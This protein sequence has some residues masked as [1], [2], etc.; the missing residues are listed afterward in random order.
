[1]QQQ[2]QQPDSAAEARER[3]KMAQPAMLPRR[4]GSTSSSG[5]G[6]E[7]FP[8]GLLVQPTPASPAASSA[9]VSVSSCPPGA[10]PPQS[11]AL[12]SQ[13]GGGGGPAGAQLKKKSGFQITSVTP[14]Q[15]SASLSSNNSI[16]EDTES[17]D[18]LDESH[19]EDFSSSEILD[20]SLSRATDLGE[21]ERSS[22][23]ETLNNFHEADSPGAVSPNQPR[24]AQQPRGLTNGSAHPLHMPHYA[25]GGHP[26]PPSHAGVP[27]PMSAGSPS[28]PSFRRLP[29]AG[30][31]ERPG[32]A[33][34]SSVAA[35]A[36]ATVAHFHAGAIAAGGAVAAA[37]SGR[38]RQVGKTLTNLAAA[39]NGMALPGG[40]HPGNVALSGGIGNGTG[41]PSNTSGSTGHTAA[42]ATATGHLQPAGS[43]SRFRVVKLD[44]SS[45]PFKKGRWTCTE[46]YDKENPGA[47]AESAPVAKTVDALLDVAS[48]RESTSGS[49]VSSTLSHYTESVG[50]GE[51]GAPPGMQPQGFHPQQMEFSTGL[52]SASAPGLPQSMSQSQL[53][54]V[55]LHP[56][57]VSYP[58]QKQGAPPPTSAMPPPLTVVGGHQPTLPFTPPPTQ[59]VPAVPVAPQPQPLPF[60]QGQ[61]QHPTAL[62]PMPMQMAPGQHVKPITQTS[63]PEYIQPPQML[64]A[65]S[66]QPGT[67]I[68]GSGSSVPVAQPPNMQLP[69]QTHIPVAPS[70]SVAQAQPAIPAAGAPAALM[71]VGQPGSAAP[72]AQRPSVASQI[73]PSVLAPS[74]AVPAPPQAAPGSQSAP[75]GLPQTLGIPPPGNLMPMQAADPLVQGMAQLPPVSPVPS[76]SAAAPVP[77]H[78]ASS[79]PPAPGSLAPSKTLA[80][81]SSMQNG[82]LVQNVSQP[83]LL[84]TG[85]HLP[86]A[87]N[88]SQFSSQSLAQ[89]I[90]SRIEEA[91][92]P[93]TESI[94]VGLTQPSG[95]AES[96]S[97]IGA[98]SALADGSMVSSLFPLK[99]L[100]L[101]SLDGEEDSSSGA[102]VV[103]ID[104]KI[105]QAM[106]LVKSHLMYAVREEVEV[107]KEQIKELI[108]KNNQLEQEN[109]L[110]KTLASPEQLA[111]FQ[112]QLQTSNS[113]AGNSSQTQGTNLQPSQA[114]APQNSG[115]S[116]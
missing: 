106:D 35:L 96:S 16:A 48:E 46:F 9:S 58:P 5:A 107:L 40:S 28:S 11:L 70:Q 42:G 37:A 86:G 98:S 45:E 68:V 21:P 112:V 89:S 100:P 64:P 69:V 31:L 63:L 79:M 3:K 24:P 32:P 41:T 56:Q 71:N 12:L 101:A 1:M 33:G 103:A 39:G 75:S 78:S 87:P 102:S 65:P 19:T 23:E 95:G 88:S 67:A 47:V 57:E 26:Q 25:Q 15:I 116:A 60:G 7:D 115:P 59:P 22:S 30:S 4:G 72:V 54:Q 8:A 84:S 14:A 94:L 111:Q 38:A 85:V 34:A 18:D 83:A 43:T 104:N 61:A 77:G 109:N 97:S 92:R 50:S 105:E 29:V 44:S 74:A 66:L 99:A 93:T 27:P 90:A 53:S 62:P 108:E 17:Y 6:L 76:V 80:Q 13:G 91:K 114:A 55:Q 110:L 51:M 113:P 10:P 20:V 49:S 36:G 73:A 81:P 52:P 82:S 2:Q